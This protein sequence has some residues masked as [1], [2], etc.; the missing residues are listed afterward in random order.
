MF[1]NM[2]YINAPLYNAFIYNEV[3]FQYNEDLQK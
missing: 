3:F 1:V 2:H